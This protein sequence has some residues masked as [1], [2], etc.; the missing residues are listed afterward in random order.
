MIDFHCHILPGLDDGPAHIDESV[1][2]AAALRDA[3]FRTIYCTPHLIK[4]CFERTTRTCCH[5]CQPYRQG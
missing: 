1:A 5:P 3:G 2:M 4:G